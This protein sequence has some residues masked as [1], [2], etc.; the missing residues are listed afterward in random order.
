M[1]TKH[2]PKIVHFIDVR[3]FQG[4]IVRIKLP[5]TNKIHVDGTEA[6]LRLKVML[7][8]GGDAGAQRNTLLSY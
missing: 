1:R 6:K 7:G 8:G 3:Y 4:N 2:L 5:H